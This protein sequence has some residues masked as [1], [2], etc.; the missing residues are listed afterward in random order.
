MNLHEAPAELLGSS[1]LENAFSEPFKRHPVV[2]PKDELTF[3][4]M[5]SAD[6]NLQQTIT[7]LYVDVFNTGYAYFELKGTDTYMQDLGRS[8]LAQINEELIDTYLVPHPGLAAMKLGMLS[9]E[10][11]VEC[12]NDAPLSVSYS[13]PGQSRLSTTIFLPVNF[14]LLAETDPH[15]V[16]SQLS[17]LASLMRDAVYG[18]INDSSKERAFAFE[19]EFIRQCQLNYPKLQFP[20]VYSERAKQYSHQDYIGLNYLPGNKLPSDVNLQ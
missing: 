4:R 14:V 5:L 12:P 7:E 19:A 9:Q 1:G 17:L 11:A 3:L 20:L 2:L 15:I 13:T 16:L 18:E 8:S 6:K 10:E